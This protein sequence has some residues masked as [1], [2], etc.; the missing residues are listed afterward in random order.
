MVDMSQA[1]LP[2]AAKTHRAVKSVPHVK[3]AP[4]ALIYLSDERRKPDY[5]ASDGETSP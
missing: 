2:T 1:G 4:H 3:P 5:Q